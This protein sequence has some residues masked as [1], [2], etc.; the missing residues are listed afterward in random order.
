MEHIDVLGKRHIYFGL[1]DEQISKRAFNRRYNS[2]IRKH[3]TRYVYIEQFEA[4][5]GYVYNR[6]KTY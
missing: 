1:D 5:D 6:L 3:G 2:I 4:V